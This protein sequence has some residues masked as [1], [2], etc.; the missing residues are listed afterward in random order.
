[1]PITICW[2]LSRQ[3]HESIRRTARIAQLWGDSRKAS[4]ACSGVDAG[5]VSRQRRQNWG[6]LGSAQLGRH[7]YRV[8]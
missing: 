1:M 6:H 4:H 2:N 5:S 3:E 7:T 8:I